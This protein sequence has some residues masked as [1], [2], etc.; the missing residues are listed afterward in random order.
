M[1]FQGRLAVALVGFLL[2]LPA[3]G[4]QSKFRGTSTGGLPQ[5][6]RVAIADTADD[7]A[8]VRQ[9]LVLYGG[10]AELFAESGFLG[11]A[12]LARPEAARRMSEDARVLFVEELAASP[13]EP[14]APA[15]APRD[16]DTSPVISARGEGGGAPFDFTVVSARGT[17]AE[18]TSDGLSGFG[19]YDYDDSGNIVK[20]GPDSY[21]Y[22]AFGRV[23][24]GEVNGQREDYEY[25][26]YGNIVKITVRN[27]NI[28][29]PAVD[30][31]TNQIDARTSGA[32]Y[33]AY[34]AAGNMTAYSGIEAYTY[35]DLAMMT[36]AATLPGNTPRRL[37][38]YSASD[39]RIATVT[40]GA[41]TEPTSSWTLR[42]PAGKVLRRLR[43]VGNGATA[44]WA[45]VQ[46][47]IYRDGQ[48]LAAEV[49]TGERVRHFHLDHLGTPR[50]VTGNGG[51]V[52][53]QPNY[54]AFGREA[55]TPLHG[56]PMQFTGHERD[57]QNLDYMHARY[58]L[59]VAGRFLSIDPT[60]DS[61]DVTRG[62]TWNRYAYVVNG[63]VN[64]ND[65][66]GRCPKNPC[67]LE[68][69]ESREL[70]SYEAKFNMPQ[71]AMEDDKNLRAIAAAFSQWGTGG[72]GA[73]A[74]RTVEAV[75]AAA[76]LGLK[77]APVG[78]MTKAERGT[79]TARFV[80][81][82]IKAARATASAIGGRTMMISADEWAKMSPA[83]K[84]LGVVGNA[85]RLALGQEDIV[86]ASA[87][88]K[89]T[90]VEMFVFRLFRREVTHVSH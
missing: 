36:S 15:A 3:A 48:L 29:E 80:V 32:F 22:D 47:Y 66:D 73:D 40:I 16:G 9:L 13:V 85:V 50:L 57:H 20:I 38:L 69:P 43:R 44:P 83:A 30:P 41:S 46:D 76:S 31:L 87:G 52:I 88:G 45:W 27:G 35:D 71:S 51:M 49:P 75:R 72:D 70:A 7:D 65:P 89:W 61:A 90:K 62:Q 14:R 11:F 53:A 63:P 39:E 54:M 82:D 78:R 17:S 33:G 68:T 84:A 55:G 8:T 25:D 42:D 34:D 64:T 67:V 18:A 19:V 6:Y 77:Y 1:K 10:R 4:D 79:G 12:M 5:R 23:A 60:W 26:Q 37:Y 56:E 81:G 21:R 2:A 24:Y 28:Y 59:P 58:Y 86:R 74:A